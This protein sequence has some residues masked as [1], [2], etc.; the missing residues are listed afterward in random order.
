M[1]RRTRGEELR[2]RLNRRDGV[3]AQRQEDSLLLMS[4]ER[5]YVAGGLGLRERAKGE[6]FSGNAEIGNHRIDEL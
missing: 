1:S 4:L 3:L 5:L 6:G 2:Q